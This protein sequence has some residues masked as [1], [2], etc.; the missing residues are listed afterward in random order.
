MRVPVAMA[1]VRLLQKLT[2]GVFRL[3]FPRLLTVLCGHLQR[4][5]QKGRDATRAVLADIVVTVGPKYL[6]FVIKELMRSLTRGYQVHVLGHAV[7]SI[8]TGLVQAQTAP[9]AIDYC[10]ED[11]FKV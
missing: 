6:M 7:F 5:D 2:A 9:G 8:L 1:I 11:L 3:E 10:R 4:R